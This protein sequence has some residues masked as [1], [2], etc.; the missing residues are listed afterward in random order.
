ME[1]KSKLEII[2]KINFNDVEIKQT[3]EMINKAKMDNL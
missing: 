1:I 2:I 3:L